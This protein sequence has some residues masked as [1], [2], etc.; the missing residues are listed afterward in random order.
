LIKHFKHSDIDFERYSATIS[1]C[2]WGRIYAMPWYLDIVSPN[3]EAL[4]N[5]DYSIVMPLPV[6]KKYGLNYLTQPYLCQQ[7]GVFSTSTPEKWIF[8]EFYNKIP[9]RISR[10]QG[11]SCDSAIYPE[12]SLRPNFFLDTSTLSDPSEGFNNN[13]IRNLKKAEKSGNTI[14][15]ISVDEY[16]DFSFVNNRDVYSEVLLPILK[17]LS[18]GLIENKHGKIYACRKDNALTAAVMIASFKNRIY[19]LSPVSSALG[20]EIQSMTFLVNTLIFEAKNKNMVIDFEGSSIEG[21]ARFYAGFGS[22]K[23]F[24]GYW[25]NFKILI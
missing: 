12:K 13:T 1:N 15:E 18:N 19:Y 24:Y 3:W 5:E 7:L 16:I 21:V 17:K 6:K 2:A 9:F 22:Q 23:E 8:E 14:S 11:N 4:A 20:K 25:K 10:F